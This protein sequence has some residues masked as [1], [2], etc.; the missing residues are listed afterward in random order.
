M[1]TRSEKNKKIR[2]EINKEARNKKIKLFIKI[3]III[4]ITLSLILGY[5]YFIGSK[6]TLVNEFKITNDTLPISFH[7][8]NISI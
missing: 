5:G 4:F 6:V 1:K 3:T 2:K 8:I 7:G